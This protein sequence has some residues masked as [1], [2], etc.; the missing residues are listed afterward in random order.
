M[1]QAVLIREAVRDA[2]VDVGVMIDTL[3]KRRARLPA[4]IVSA[5]DAILLVVA[6]DATAG[7]GW[8]EWAVGC[9]AHRI[10]ARVHAP[11][12]V[13]LVCGAVPV[14]A[15][16]VVGRAH[17]RHA[18]RRRVERRRVAHADQRQYARPPDRAQHAC[19]GAHRVHVVVRARV[20]TRLLHR[21]PCWRDAFGIHTA[22]DRRECHR[23]VGL[24]LGEHVHLVVPLRR[25]R[26]QRLCVLQYAVARHT[27]EPVGVGRV[28]AEL[29][30]G[31]RTVCC[32]FG[33]GVPRR[34]QPR[35]HVGDDAP[36]CAC[37][38][39]RVLGADRLV[40]ALDRH[41]VLVEHAV[42][43]RADFVAF[44]TGT[45]GVHGRRQLRGRIRR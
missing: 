32:D 13:G 42:Q 16:S 26:R 34:C 11:R 12:F 5:G 15:A 2:V 17:A 45:V 14:A 10:R 7:S 39:Q 40:D 3:G 41:V 4:S 18:I 6:R 38:Q 28:G 22:I 19:C 24:P 20:R 44:G 27:G 8:V 43:R 36:H 23:G 1:C 30:L 21:L 37:A 33:D 31:G 25:R 29:Q 9:D 35:R